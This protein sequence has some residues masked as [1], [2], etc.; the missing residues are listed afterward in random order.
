MSDTPA[1]SGAELDRMS[2]TPAKA[3]SILGDDGS[4]MK[5]DAGESSPPLLG[6]GRRLS[7]LEAS[8]QKKR[9]AAQDMGVPIEAAPV[10]LLSTSKQDVSFL[11]F[12]SPLPTLVLQK[13]L[14][15]PVARPRAMGRRT[16]C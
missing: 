7:D 9:A 6:W 5:E 8:V 16:K 4:P 15:S 3:A 12:D 2:D 11:S 13:R 10:L 14:L 1:K